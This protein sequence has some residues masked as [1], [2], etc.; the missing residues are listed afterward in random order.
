MLFFRHWENYIWNVI[1]Y[2]YKLH[3]QNRVNYNRGIPTCERLPIF[4][5]SVSIL[6]SKNTYFVY[7]NRQPFTSWNYSITKSLKNLVMRYQT[8]I[9][10]Y[11]MR[12]ISYTLLLHYNAIIFLI[13]GWQSNTSNICNTCS[14]TLRIRKFRLILSSSTLH[15]RP[16]LKP[17][18]VGS[19]LIS[20]RAHP[21]LTHI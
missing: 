2:N 6:L 13:S 1:N 12:I 18:V 7:E 10:F 19:I 15:I 8:R 14:V 21:H 4:M 16:G 3:C 11:L 17:E 5:R 9:S 20:L